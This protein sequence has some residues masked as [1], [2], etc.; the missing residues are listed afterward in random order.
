MRLR[1]KSLRRDRRR[2]RLDPERWRAARSPPSVMPLSF[3]PLIWPRY[4]LMARKHPRAPDSRFRVIALSISWRR[5]SIA[6]FGL[7]SLPELKLV[8]RSVD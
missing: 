1:G 6:V 8:A 4:L 3:D 7:Y 2:T 5:G